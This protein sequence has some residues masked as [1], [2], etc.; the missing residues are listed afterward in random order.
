MAFLA[1]GKELIEYDNKFC[2]NVFVGEVGYLDE[3]VFV[4]KL[5]NRVLKIRYMRPRDHS[6]TRCGGFVNTL[7]AVRYQAAADKDNIGERIRRA[8]FADA[9]EQYNLGRRIAIAWR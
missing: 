7:P 1:V 4:Q 2:H 8:E 9:V 3:R 6:F 5:F